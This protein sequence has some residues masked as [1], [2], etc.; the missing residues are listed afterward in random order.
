MN[1]MTPVRFPILALVLLVMFAGSDCLAQSKAGDLKLTPRVF[2]SAGGEKVDVELGQL[3]VPENRTRPDSRLIKLAFVRFKST[4]KT[5]AAPIV[6]L[7]G[8]PGGSGMAAARGPRFPLFMAMREVAD[9]IALDQRGVGMSEPNLECKERITLTPDKPYSRA[10]VLDL[11]RAQSRVCADNFRQQGVDLTGY[12]TNESADDLED[13]RKALGA[14]KISLWA[15]S[16]GTHLA[17]ATIKRHQESIDRMILAGV[18]G[19]AHTIK[20]PSNIQRHLEHIDALVSIDPNLSQEIPSFLAL[21]KKVLYRLEREPVT[22]EVTDPISKQPTKVVLNKFA[23]QVLTTFSFGSGEAGLPARYYAMSK[24][25]FSGPAQGWLGFSR[26]QNV[27]SA[28]AYMMDCASGVSPERRQEIAREAK[29]ALLEDVMDFPLP[30]VCD[31]WGNP[32]AGSKFRAP[33]KSKVPV[34]FISGTFDVRTPP[35]NAEEVRLGFPNSFHL[36]IAGA[37]HSD[38]LFLSSPLIKEVMMEFMKGQQISTTR[39]TLAPVKF[40]QVTKQ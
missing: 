33:A 3:T 36:I 24:G 37:V 5:P 17:L 15:I 27:G 40:V 4:A 39:I 13:L 20:L 22:V 29:T 30:D 38:P 10:Q 9:V 8:G 14:E 35:S 26:G 25:D 7:A 21:V 34:L 28:M 18:E 12:N 2:E 6:Y 1:K 16:Y 11:F 32:D 31:A 23:I 19:P